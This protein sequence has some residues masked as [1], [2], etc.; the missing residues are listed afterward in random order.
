MA[1]SE[2]KFD[3]MFE[4][5]IADCWIIG[6]IESMLR[7]SAL[8]DSE[9][10]RI[11]SDLATMT[12]VKAEETVEHLIPTLVQNDVREQYKQMI[13]AGVF[14]FHKEDEEERQISCCNID[15]TDYDIKMCPK[16]K[17]HC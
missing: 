7:I 5:P 15:I 13:R 12:Q 3:S 10:D 11:Y 6:R 1:F 2:D 9:K 14:D 4:D 16:C 8:P 17:E